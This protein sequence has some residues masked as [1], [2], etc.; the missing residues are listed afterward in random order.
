MD[1]I[2]EIDASGV[3]ILTLLCV[4]VELALHFLQLR[5]SRPSAQEIALQKEHATLA[6][7]A[8]KLNSVDMFVEHSKVLRQMNTVKKQ[9]QTLAVERIAKSSVPGFV[10]YV[11]PLLLIAVVVY[12]WS[13]PL[14]VFPPGHLM[15]V[16]RLVAMPLF[17]IGSVSAGGWWILCRRVTS[18]LLK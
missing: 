10:G 18:R 2:Q 17:P 16:E 14:V 6:A 12:F 8:K 1:L 5:G 7:K 11:Q 4:L 15:P 3:L 9:E 13:S